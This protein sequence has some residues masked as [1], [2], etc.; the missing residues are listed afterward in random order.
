MH[1]VTDIIHGPCLTDEN[2]IYENGIYDV[3]MCV[4]CKTWVSSA[5]P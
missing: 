1:Y 3:A 5:V 2:G 4:H